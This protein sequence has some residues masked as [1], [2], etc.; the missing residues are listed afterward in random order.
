MD[1]F[2]RGA[3]MVL[4]FLVALLL[5]AVLYFGTIWWMNQPPIPS[6]IKLTEAEKA[7]I[8]AR[9]KYHGIWAS[10]YDPE[11]GESYFYRDGKKCRL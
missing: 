9:H 3:S 8:E 4:K 2:D 1:E 5:I 11:T 6:A 7:W 10:I